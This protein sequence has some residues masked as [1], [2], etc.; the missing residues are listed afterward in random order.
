MIYAM[1]ERFS[2]YS[3]FPNGHQKWFS[4]LLVYLGCFS[5][6]SAVAQSYLPVQRHR[7]VLNNNQYIL[8]RDT[9]KSPVVYCHA[10]PYS[11]SA[12]SIHGTVP[13]IPIQLQEIQLTRTANLDSADIRVFYNGFSEQARNAFQYA[14]DI[15]RGFIKTDV[16]VHIFANWRTLD[17]GTLGSAYSGDLTSIGLIRN[18]TGATRENTWF[19]MAIAE[20]LN[21]RKINE[22]WESD[23]VANFNSDLPEWY[24]GIDGKCPPDKY[25][26]A[27]VVLHEICHG[28]GFFSTNSRDTLSGQNGYFGFYGLGTGYPSI[29]DTYIQ[30]GQGRKLTD[31]NIFPNP[32]RGMLNMYTSNDVYFNS[33]HA[34]AANNN[35][36]PKLYAPSAYTQGSSIAHLDEYTYPDGTINSLMGPIARKGSSVHDPG[37]IVKG[38]M[39]DLGWRSLRIF[40]DPLSDR[41]DRKAPITFLARIISDDSLFYDS[42]LVYYSFD[43][44]FTPFQT[45]VMTPTGNPDEFSA[46]I[47][48]NGNNGTVTYYIKAKDR[49][50]HEATSPLTVPDRY[51]EFYIQRDAFSPYLFHQP[52]NQRFLNDTLPV[53]VYAVDNLAINAVTMEYSINKIPQTAIALALTGDSGSSYLYKGYFPH[54]PMIMPG[55]SV[56][57]RIVATDGA[58]RPNRAYYPASGYYQFIME[59][60]LNAVNSYSNDFNS[61]STDFLTQDGLFHIGSEKGFNDGA[62][63][64]RHPY[65]DGPYPFDYTS[66]VVQFRYPVVLKEPTSI[67]TFDEVLLVQPASLTSDYRSTDFIDYVVVEGSKDKG[68]SWVV[69]TN[70]YNTN[71]NKDWTDAYKSKMDADTNSLATGNATLYRKRVINLLLNS[72]FIGG[73]PGSNTEAGDSILIRFRLIADQ[74]FHGW[75]WAIDNFNIQTTPYSE[76]GNTGTKFVED[77]LYFFPNPSKGDVTVVANSRQA[78]TTMRTE[79]RDVFGSLVYAKEWEFAETKTYRNY[80]PVQFLAQG[81][82]F[83]SIVYGDQKVVRKL[84]ME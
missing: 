44:L 62:I 12:C 17:Q 71:S 84:I 45:A 29:F 10:S 23:I 11:Q 64:S 14:V 13:G 31:R 24:Y 72:Y 19:P 32:S 49:A 81:V 51:Y 59:G 5:L 70:P 46:T 42:L 60:H 16:P 21:G 18:F 79:I 47:P 68:Y 8:R 6:S 37:P 74:K 77:N 52:I 54:D 61:P 39:D 20:K 25:D 26:L 2:Y 35:Q 48:A 65:N 27:S 28:L 76:K 67:L 50:G 4:M 36:L 58:A 1:K 78:F 33:V 30:D 34:I 7:H 41:E 80:L 53:M 63:H 3:T 43:R 56:Q 22:D 66:D 75:G 83:F 38:M 69:L 73:N 57:Y 9:M 82:Y 15:W 55:D 40:H